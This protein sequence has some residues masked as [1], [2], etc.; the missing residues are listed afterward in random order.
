MVK[1]ERVKFQPCSE[2][3]RLILMDNTTDVILIGGGA[4][5]GKSRICL[6]KNLDGIKDSKFRCVILRRFEPELKKQGGLIDESKN[7]Y[8][9]FT[10][11]PYKSQ[12]KLWEFPSGATIG[13]SAISCDD[14]LG[15]WQG[16]QLTRK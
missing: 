3:Q 7:V 9:H 2:K 6:T 1:K 11:I 13:F 5:G 8:P 12:Q 16:S 15:S 14:D 4:G 10:K